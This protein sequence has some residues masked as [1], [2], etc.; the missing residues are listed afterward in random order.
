MNAQ[1]EL[2][3]IRAL[4][5]EDISAA[6]ELKI[7]RAL[8]SGKG[9]ADD[10]LGRPKS[11][12]GMDRAPSFSDLRASASD[13]DDGFDYD[14]GAAGG[15]RAKISFGE[16]AE[17]KEL[18]LRKIVGEE[19]YTKDSKGL[20]ALTEA[21]QLSQGMEPI[22]QNLIIE[23]EGFSM[24]DI[25]DLA[26]IAPETIGAVIG[27]VLGAPGLVTGAVGAAAGAGL[28]Q[29]AEEGIESL[30][31]IQRQSLGEVGI[32]VAREAALAG[33]LDFAG[34]AIFKL[35]KM[36]IGAAGKGVNAGARAMGQVERE[37]GADQANLA[38]KIMD[39]DVPGQPSYAAAGMPAGIAKA[40]QIAGAIGGNEQKRAMAN[41][42]FALNEKEKLLGEAGISTVD[43]LA[44]VIRNSV[45]AKAKQL[46]DGLKAAQGAHMKAIDDTISMLT[47]TTKSGGEIDD[48]VLESL[49]KNYEEFMKQSKIQFQNVD[50]TLSGV[51]GRVT[52]NGV[53]KEVVGGEMPIFDIKAMKTRFG[54]IIDSQY[55]GA[56]KVAPDEFLEIGRQID[57]LNAVGAKEGFTTFN[58]LKELR[59]NINDTLM[60][61]ALGI[62]DTTPRR[63]L[64]GLKSDIDR[65]MDPSNYK[66]GGLKLTGVG[67]AQ[68]AKTVKKAM[69]QLLDARASYR[70]E[71]KL[72]NDLE[73]LG[74]IRNLGDSGEN[75]KLTAGRL[76]DRITDSPK[77]I[78]A[79]LNSADSSLSQIS[80][81][82]L[83]QTLAKSYLDDALLVANKDF[84]DPLAFNGVQFNNKIKKLGKSGKLLFGDQWG[85]VQ[86]LSKALSYNGVKK[87]DDQIMQRIIAQNPSDNIVQTLKSVKDAQIGLDKALST[88]A[89]K[90][91]AD[92]TI[93]PEEA[94]SLLL[95]R[96]TSASQMDRVMGFFNGNDA[97]K[98][99]IRRTIISDILGSVDEDIFVNEAAASSLRKALE[100]YKPD[101][102]NKVL[103]KQAVDDIRELSEMLVLLSDT[104]KKGAGSLAADAIRTGMVTNPAVNFKK[105]M[106]FKALNYMLNNPQTLRAAIAMKAG[107][108]SPQATAQSLSQAL[109]E[110]FA[111]ATGSGASLTERATGAGKSLVA[112]LQAANRGQT[113][114]RQGGARALFADQEARG[115]APQAPRTSVPEVS[116]PMSVD[117][118]QIT[119]S[120]DPQFVRQQMNLRERAKSNPYIASTLLGGLG[121]VGLL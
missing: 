37:L 75:V 117:D 24:R 102:L 20:L 95:S 19:G 11:N 27:G 105:G 74:I 68:N 90:N 120:V 13:R 119:Q 77:R 114:V 97:A 4:S 84:G 18:I 63:L 62:K 39:A 87:I 45:P 48:F 65:M 86:S 16:T 115:I 107:R 80:R 91:L 8:D 113:A 17:E 33:T 44:E 57:Q 76:F 70:G 15:L 38:L 31:G 118:L 10:I 56:N 14:T 116:M 26:G 103:G 58:G 25:S 106:R 1:D 53:E 2:R 47:K 121:N 61:P 73:T 21:G 41:I 36:A 94:A 67:G 54:D 40:S 79:V 5:S 9:S 3:L 29:A 23:D 69:G 34:N 43:D 72:F 22:G 82:E 104:G 85:E 83:R 89:L 49:V 81:E 55:A 7:S 51:K 111:Q 100:A 92:G 12:I 30:L 35:G 112:G 28:G 60:D 42:R 78:A 98:E 109:N 64:N 32:D 101:M 59:K 99:T 52:I 46:E 50:N 71:I 66:S 110:S 88:K 6:D 93:A 108:T 96:N